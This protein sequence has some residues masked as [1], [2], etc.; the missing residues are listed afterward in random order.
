MQYNHVPYINKYVHTVIRA[1]GVDVFVVPNTINVHVYSSLLCC[2]NVAYGIDF[3][4]AA[5]VDETDDDIVSC[6]FIFFE[7][8]DGNVVV[9]VVVVGGRVVGFAIVDVFLDNNGY[10]YTDDDGD[11]VD[12]D[13]NDGDYNDGDYNGDVMLIMIMMEIIMVT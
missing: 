8:D 6:L 7:N 5:A 9:V 11:D 1:A 3:D 10:A 4:A 2:L 12:D 13:N